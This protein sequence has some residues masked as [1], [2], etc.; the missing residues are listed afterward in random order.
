[1]KTIEVDDEVYAYIAG[2]TRA[3]GELAS[4]ILRRELKMPATGEQTGDERQDLGESHELSEVLEGLRLKLATTAVE[5]F[6]IILS[7]AF[8]MRPKDF[9]NILEV[10]GRDR[11]YFATNRSC[12]VERGQ[13]TQ[14][15]QIPGTEYW[16]MTNSPTSQKASMLFD[17]LRA[18]GFSEDACRE[19][20]Y[21]LSR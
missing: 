18:I 2:K 7:E 13:S 20:R 17:A 15:K 8:K 14:P 3:I 19:A 4:D 6:L 12:I 21:A 10:R 5:K 9:P 16:V 11:I 1:M